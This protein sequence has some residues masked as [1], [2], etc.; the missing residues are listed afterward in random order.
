MPN[1]DFFQVYSFGC[2]DLS[3]C[4]AGRCARS[5]L[6]GGR[7]AG[8]GY[9]GTGEA[10]QCASVC[11]SSVAIAVFSHGARMSKLKIPS[12]LPSR[13]AGVITGFTIVTRDTAQLQHAFTYQHFCSYTRS[14]DVFLQLS[15]ATSAYFSLC[16][17]W[18]TSLAV[19]HCFALV[20]ILQPSR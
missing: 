16:Y 12:V 13:S 7:R 8:A 14:I 10:G 11:E 18:Q 9:Q 1:V 15:M 2:R 17:L 5:G 4:D 19:G 3:R 6:T 20:T